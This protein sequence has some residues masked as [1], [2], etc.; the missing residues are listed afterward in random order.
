MNTAE[1]GDYAHYKCQIVHEEILSLPVVTNND[2]Y[3]LLY[4]I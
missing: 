4:A 1:Y 2:Q 3:H